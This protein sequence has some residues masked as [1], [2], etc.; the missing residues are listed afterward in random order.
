MKILYKTWAVVTLLLGT[1]ALL[2]MAEIFG[3]KEKKDESEKEA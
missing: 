2:T 1:T 3:K